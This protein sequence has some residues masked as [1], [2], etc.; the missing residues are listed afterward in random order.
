[1]RLCVFCAEPVHGGDCFHPE[2]KELFLMPEIRVY[3]EAALDMEGDLDP[4]CELSITGL[5]HRAVALDLYRELED[6]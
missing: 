1:M 6:K 5:D 3:R 4:T 2:C